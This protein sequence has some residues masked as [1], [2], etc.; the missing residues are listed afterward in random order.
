MV[1]LIKKYSNLIVCRTFSKAYGLAGC[2]VG[3]LLRNK[4]LAKRLYNLR[5]MYEINSIGAMIV[6]EILKKIR[7]LLKIKRPIR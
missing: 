7:M 4:N 6:N 1:P 3:F 2:R 5:P